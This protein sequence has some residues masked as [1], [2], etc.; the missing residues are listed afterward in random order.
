MVSDKS[1]TKGAAVH[2]QNR[3][4]LG[5]SKIGCMLNFLLIGVIAAIGVKVFPVYHSNNQ[6]AEAAGEIASRAAN[7]NQ[8]TIK[9]QIMEKAREFN[10]TQALAP[11]AVTVSRVSSKDGGMCTVRIRYERE[12]NIY[13]FAAIKLS[14]NKEIA[15]PFM[16][17]LI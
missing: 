10:I 9:A 4:K 11:G 2:A 7:L 1:L 8:D 6:L 5:G 14:T 13:G 17:S 12:I 15:K 3:A 16:T